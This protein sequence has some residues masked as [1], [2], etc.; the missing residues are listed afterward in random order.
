MSEAVRPESGSDAERAWCAA[1]VQAEHLRQ[2]Y[3]QHQSAADIAELEL[4][5]LW[6]HL[7]IAERR[8]D[9]L[10]SRLG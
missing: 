9:E 7:W 1:L 4:E 3:V 2:N 10:F 6:L 5:S 8:R